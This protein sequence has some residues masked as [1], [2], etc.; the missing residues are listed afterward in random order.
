MA[1][2]NRCFRQ[3]HPLKQKTA[4][5]GITGEAVFVVQKLHTIA[6]LI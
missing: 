5:A 3:I 1:K 6:L 2:Q 4:P